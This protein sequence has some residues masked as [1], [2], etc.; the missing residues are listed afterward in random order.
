VLKGI[1]LEA[2]TSHNTNPI[3]QFRH[4]FSLSTVPTILNMKSTLISL[5]MSLLLLATIHAAPLPAGSVCANSA[6]HTL[7]H[8]S[9]TNP[10]TPSKPASPSRPFG[11]SGTPTTMGST[12]ILYAARRMATAARIQRMT[13]M[14]LLGTWLV[15][16][17]RGRRLLELCI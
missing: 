17:L 15:D 2:L 1:I 13:M 4:R 11:A 16:R 6:F 8:S 5:A 10:R 3:N 14:G 7:N 9:L 12:S